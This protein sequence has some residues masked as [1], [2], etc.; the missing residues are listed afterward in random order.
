[1]AVLALDP[2]RPEPPSTPQGK[3]AAAYPRKVSL[4]RSHVISTL[5]VSEPEP[6]DPP[7][8]EQARSREK[9]GFT[10]P[11]KDRV[12]AELAMKQA[13]PKT[14]RGLVSGPTG[15]FRPWHQS[16][17]LYP[18]PAVGFKAATSADPLVKG[19]LQLLTDIE[20]YPYRHTAWGSQHFLRQPRQ[21]GQ[22]RQRL[23]DRLDMS[24]AHEDLDPDRDHP[25]ER[26]LGQALF[27][28]RAR[29]WL[30]EFCADEG[31]PELAASLLLCLCR[32]PTLAL[33]AWEEQLIAR[34]LACDDGEIRDA[35]VQL[36]ASWGGDHLQGLLQAHQDSEDW[37]QDSIRSVLADWSI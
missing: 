22:D 29:R 27:S 9:M 5:S 7:Y 18:D 20:W 4:S 10:V 33:V 6:G 30:V 25:A 14:A 1:M 34:A 24:F 16:H 32:Q 13:P 31:H 8:R 11:Y 35:A 15:P 21:E 3:I 28:P 19:S 17:E 36:A 2:D 23:W 37:L 12:P 26:T